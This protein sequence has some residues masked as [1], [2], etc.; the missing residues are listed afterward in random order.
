MDKFSLIR[1]SK[2]EEFTV[3]RNISSELFIKEV[4]IQKIL[5]NNQDDTMEG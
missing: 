1:L 5:M 3:V 4:I 2:A